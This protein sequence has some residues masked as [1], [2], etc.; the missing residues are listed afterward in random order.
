MKNKNAFKFLTF[1]LAIFGLVL[2]ASPFLLK[3]P[4]NKAAFADSGDAVTIANVDFNITVG[5]DGVLHIKEKFDVTF[6]RSSLSEVVVY[7]PYEGYIYRQEGDEV[8]KYQYLAKINNYSLTKGQSGAEELR[9]YHDE[10]GAEG[11]ITFGIKN[12]SGYYSF[13]DTRTYTINYDYNMYNAGPKGYSEVFF[14]LISDLTGMST[15]NVTF[16]ITL[17][18]DV[19]M[20]TFNPV[21][22]VGKAGSTE[23]FDNFTISGRT[24]TSNTGVDLGANEGITYWHILPENYLNVKKPSIALPVIAL[25]S[26]LVGVAVMIALK[27]R[28]GQRGEVLSP[29]EFNITGEIEPG[30]AEFYYKNNI[31]TKSVGATI[32]HLAN[33]GY[34]SVILSD[35]DK[36]KPV[37]FRKLRDAGSELTSSER[38]I[39][40]G[41]FSVSNTKIMT[42]EEEFVE[43]AKTLDKSVLNDALKKL[44]ENEGG[45]L[46]STLADAGVMSKTLR[47]YSAKGCALGEII[48]RFYGAIGGKP[49]NLPKPEIVVKLDDLNDEKFYKS[50]NTALTRIRN[51]NEH[52]IY[53]EKSK[54]GI[55]ACNLIAAVGLIL[56]FVFTLFAAKQWVGFTP[57]Q[58]L[59]NAWFVGFAAI[60]LLVLTKT[61]AII[62]IFAYAFLAVFT[63]MPT[64]G[65][66][67]NG[68]KVVDPAGLFAIAIFVW[69]V[70][71]CI[72]VKPKY[73][74]AAAKLRGRVLGLRNYI[75]MAEKAQLEM[76]VNET[77]EIFYNV[78]PFAYVLGVSDVWMDKFKDIKIPNPTF[79]EGVNDISTFDAFMF[80]NMVGNING[81]VARNLNLQAM[82]AGAASFKSVS[83]SFG[84]G[85]GGG[86]SGGGFSGGGGGGS[87]FGAR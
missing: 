49:T 33:L 6:N 15:S 58:F 55:A 74:E 8:K 73:T 30:I 52:K 60:I 5:E 56:V 29:V 4:T 21:F 19:D 27:I 53:E 87:S 57:S 25:V 2:L 82:R 3:D 76:L 68:L 14:N 46:E 26:A 18:K 77:P 34:I 50:A 62:N 41:M 22:Y 13:G 35:D 20:S 70:A 47:T 64:I 79:V 72:R 10:A 48:S 83:R 75:K 67:S 44:P 80:G 9:F 28:N 86:F 40:D 12:T 61:P 31:S 45:L 42:A 17:P 78:L 23:T 51:L 11:F 81:A 69:L 36:H 85:S 59:F 37:A 66:Y 63:I 16:S 71:I 54:K 43:V 32:M 39:F 84:G 38:E 1:L 65:V 7:I 24:I